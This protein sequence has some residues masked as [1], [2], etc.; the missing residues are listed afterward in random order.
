MREGGDANDDAAIQVSDILRAQA[1]PCDI[2]N[3]KLF[4]Y[5]ANVRIVLLS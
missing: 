2:V 5:F 4:M 3:L 1:Q